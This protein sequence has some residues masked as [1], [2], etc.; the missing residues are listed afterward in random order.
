[1][2]RNS[3]D[4]AFW[5]VWM[6]FA[7]V[8][9]VVQG[10]TLCPILAYVCG[11]TQNS[12]LGGAVTGYLLQWTFLNAVQSSD[13][14]HREIICVVFVCICT[15]I[16]GQYLGTL[17]LFCLRLKRKSV[18]QRF[19]C[20]RNKLCIPSHPMLLGVVLGLVTIFPSLTMLYPAWPSPIPGT[21]PGLVLFS[22]FLASGL[23][24]SYAGAL[25]V[26]PVKLPQMNPGD[27][28]EVQNAYSVLEAYE[29]R[30]P[31]QELPEITSTSVI[32]TR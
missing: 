31:I 14:S 7:M 1:M 20:T 30:E 22:P 21:V 17:V 5:I 28:V 18:Q 24:A 16:T 15:W 19:P 23:L 12:V 3:L 29:N 4:I 9:Q 32:R 25:E 10:L 27:L 2:N 11:V 6:A 8:P 13:A 26:L